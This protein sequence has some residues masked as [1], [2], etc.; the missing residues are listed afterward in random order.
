MPHIR[1]TQGTKQYGELPLE[2]PTSLYRVGCGCPYFSQAPQMLLMCRLG[3]EAPSQPT[4]LAMCTQRRKVPC[5]HPGFTASSGT[6]TQTLLLPTRDSRGSLL[7]GQHGTGLSSRRV[8]LSTGK[9]QHASCT[10]CEG[11]T[12]CAPLR[13]HCVIPLCSQG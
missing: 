12:S 10:I 3:G 4:L 11:G 7:W 2:T 13:V 6:G 8:H 1:L 5:L 9:G